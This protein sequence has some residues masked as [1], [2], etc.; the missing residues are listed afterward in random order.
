[1]PYTAAT[2]L[3]YEHLKRATAIIR[4]QIQQQLILDGVEDPPDWSLMKVSGPTQEQD[5][6]GRPW[7][8]Y[9]GTLD[10]PPV[11]ETP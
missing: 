1:M 2:A 5:F 8:W 7:F 11:K 10:W 6:Y 4:Q 9:Q 3:P